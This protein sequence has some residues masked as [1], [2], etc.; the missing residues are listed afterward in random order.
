MPIA[1]RYDISY[2]A[3]RPLL[4]MLGLGPRFS[5]VEIDGLDLGVAMGWGFRARF[6]ISSIRSVV[7][8]EGTTRN[9]GVHGFAGLYLVNGKGSGLVTLTIE[10]TAKARLMG[11]PVKLRTLSVSL[12]APE[13][14]IAEI[15]AHIR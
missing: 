7:P 5:H 14:F 4:S 11:F 6:P 9:I 12:E 1:K 13:Q 8:Y 10:P 2:G 15:S 3:L